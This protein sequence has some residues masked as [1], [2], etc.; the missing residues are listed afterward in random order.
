MSNRSKRPAEARALARF[1][2]PVHAFL[3][4]ALLLFVPATSPAEDF[5]FN[6]PVRLNNLNP[7][8][9][10]VR[11]TCRVYDDGGRQIARSDGPAAANRWYSVGRNFSRTVTLK[12]DVD[13]GHH[14]SEAR[15]YRCWMGLQV[16]DTP[17]GSRRTIPRSA[18]CNPD[19]TTYYSDSLACNRSRPFAPMVEG[20]ISASATPAAR[21]DAAPKGSF[22]PTQRLPA[23]TLDTQ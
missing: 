1:R 22:V 9:E 3:A 18:I 2:T 21:P 7:D 12:F 8:V 17:D 15:T 13:R 16:R 19:D 10:L 6:V 11:I 23:P 4:A 20:T 14:P 5:T